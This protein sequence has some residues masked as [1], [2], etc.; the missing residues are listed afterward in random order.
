M[1]LLKKLR[2][3]LLFLVVAVIIIAVLL[4]GQQPEAVPQ[5][6][7]E[8]ITGGVYEEAVVGSLTRLNPLLT[9]FNPVDDDPVSLLFRGLIRFD[10]KGLPQPDLAESWGISRD[11][12]SR[13]FVGRCRGQHIRGSDL[14]WLIIQ[15]LDL[16]THQP[17]IF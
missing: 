3:P 11:G 13:Q 4:W 8:P 17:F 14:D 16:L 12:D 9:Y 6:T 7:P 5:E 1:E 2:W 15:G 10:S